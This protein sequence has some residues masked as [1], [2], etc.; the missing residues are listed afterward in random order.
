MKETSLSKFN[1]SCCFS[2]DAAQYNVIGRVRELN[3]LKATVDAGVLSKL[4]ANGVDL[5]TIEKVLPLAEQFGLL[6]LAAN[7]QQLLVNG[8]APLLVEGAPLLLPVVAGALAVGPSAFYFAAATCG[9]LEAY[10]V[11]TDAQLPLVGLNAGV[12][13]GLLLVPLGVI[14]AGVGT[15]LSNAKK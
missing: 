15:A 14:S 4:E 6:S 11:A 5:E 1:V 7:N 13:L 9:A 8:V 12:F 2:S 10:L 3:L